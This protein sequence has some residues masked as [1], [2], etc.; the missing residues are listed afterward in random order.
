[1]YKRLTTDNDNSVCFV[2]IV[3]KGLEYRSTQFR[4]YGN[5]LMLRRSRLPPLEEPVN[6][7]GEYYITEVLDYNLCFWMENVLIE[8]MI[9]SHFISL[10]PKIFRR[11]IC[12]PAKSKLSSE[13][14]VVLMLV[15]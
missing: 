9:D 7:R 1:M 13:G 6:S 11:R 15:G 5:Y 14:A 12:N 2:W 8:G 10:D 4:Q 3:V